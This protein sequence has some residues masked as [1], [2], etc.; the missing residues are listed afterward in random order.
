MSETNNN[1]TIDSSFF[2]MHHLYEFNNLMHENNII[3]IYEGDFSQEVA[4]SVLS[5]TE[6]KLINENVEEVTKKKI[7][8]VM[9][10]SLQNICKH[11]SLEANTQ[12]VFLIG[13]DE[14]Y[15]NIISGNPIDKT[16]VEKVMNT[17]DHINSLDEEGIKQ[18][19]KQT[20]LNSTLSDVGGA[21]LGFIDMAK[22]TGNKMLYQFEEIDDKFY[23]FTLMVQVSN[24]SI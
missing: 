22:R 15:F 6:K 11:H 20:R 23:F 17:L 4:K 5:M 16:N 24:S 14:K 1:I 9:I 10:E 21:G 3:L 12:S 7:Y 8:N 13:A 2:N 19:F 18:L